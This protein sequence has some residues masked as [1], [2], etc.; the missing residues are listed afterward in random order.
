MGLVLS[1]EARVS[2]GRERKRELRAAL[3]HFVTGKI[4]P[5][6]AKQLRGMLA[7]AKDAEPEFY[8]R[9][10]T[11]Y[12]KDALEKLA[13]APQERPTRSMIGTRGS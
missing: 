5:T 4:T 9:M 3:H 12:G 6:A 10:E 7:F 11:R 8:A 2:L 13:K 1:N